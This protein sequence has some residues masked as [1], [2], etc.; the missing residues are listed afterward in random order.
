M[1]KL[2]STL[3]RFFCNV[4][5]IF[6][7]ISSKPMRSHHHFPI[8]GTVRTKENGDTDQGRTWLLQVPTAS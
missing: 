7:K 1:T 4:K 6:Q 5:F 2:Y 3:S 8:S